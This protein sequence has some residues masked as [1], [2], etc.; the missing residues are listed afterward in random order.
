MTFLSFSWLFG[1]LVMLHGFLDLNFK[2]YAFVV[3]GLIKGEIEKSSGQFLGLIVMSLDLAR[4]YLCPLFIW[5]IMFVCLVVCMG[6]VRH[7]VQRR[8]S[9]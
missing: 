5:R 2:L 1:L 8:G 3:T 6:Q 9:W 7:D 4:F